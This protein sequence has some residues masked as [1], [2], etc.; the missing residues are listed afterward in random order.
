VKILLQRFSIVLVVAIY[1]ISIAGCGAHKGIEKKARKQYQQ[2]DYDGAVFTCAKSLRIKPDYDK[3]QF[4]IQD[5][6]KAAVIGHSDRIK[7]IKNTTEKFRWDDVVLE[8]TQLIELNNTIKALPTL[9]DKNTKLEIKFDIVDYS[10]VLTEANT[11]AAESHY[12]EGLRLKPNLELDV[13][14]QAAKEF[15]AAEKYHP[16]Y[17]DAAV[18]YEQCRKAGLKRMA[19]IPFDDKSGK[20]GQFGAISETIVDDIISEVINDPSATEFL[21]IISRDQ[22]ELIAAE[23]KLGASAMM[24][25]K[26]VVEIGKL[27]GVHE[28]LTG[29]ITQIIY[30]PERTTKKA[31]REKGRAVV[32]TEKYVDDKGKTRERN[33]Y[34]DVFANVNTYTKTANA[35]ISGSYR[36]IEIT[37]AKIKKS[38]SFTKEKSFYYQ[39]ATFKGDQRALGGESRGLASKTEQFAPVKEELVSDASRILSKSLAQS[40]IEYAR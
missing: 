29:K 9:I 25:D 17:K 18:F 2:G 21:E 7:Q 15:K 30:T 5:A 3:A 35:S 16:G 27:L 33:V 20:Q 19:I 36:I 38:D 22:L 40:L 26:S 1:L 39:W 34:G 13:Q 4:L 8:Y 14:K 28:I 37:T 11:N 23:H 32:G 24:D 31:V 12:Q 10:Q 6:F